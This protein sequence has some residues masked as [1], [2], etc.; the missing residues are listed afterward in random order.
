[1]ISLQS[2]IKSSDKITEH[3][4]SLLSNSSLILKNIYEGLH[5]TRFA[6]KG[7]NFWQFKE[8]SQ[9]ENVASIDWRK[10]ASSKK[11]LIKQNEKELSKTIYLYFDNSLSMNYRSNYSSHSKLYISALL[12]LSLCKLFSY[13]KEEVF[14]FNSE[15]KPIKCS[16]NINNFNNSFLTNNK[17]HNLPD[18]NFF[19]DKSLCFFFSDFM[20]EKKD[21]NKLLYK[22]KKRGIIGY[23]IQVLDPM[24]ISLK[25]QANVMLKD[26]ETKKIMSLHNDKD[27]L[28]AYQRKL[29]ELEMEL[30]K[31]CFNSGWKYLKFIT[32][33]NISKFLIDLSKTF[34]LNKK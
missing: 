26:L 23:L 25:F 14:I 29:N 5:S 10:S 34:A 33:Q 1:M 3:L 32:N 27:I 20:Y 12:T 22:F 21:L 13:N 18:L 6:G 8:Y 16:N 4:P 7:E 17:K 9:G 15:V 24:E 2:L 11:I 31:I 28:N 30:K 19:K